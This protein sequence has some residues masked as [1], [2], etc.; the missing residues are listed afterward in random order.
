MNIRKIADVLVMIDKSIPTM[1]ELEFVRGMVKGVNFLFLKEG[2]NLRLMIN[3]L[4][5]FVLF[6]DKD[7]VVITKELSCDNIT[8]TRDSNMAVIKVNEGLT[9]TINVTEKWVKVERS[10][11]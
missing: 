6:Q 10:F 4:D 11:T 9:F 8:V 5:K 1:D 3:E 2:K 7:C